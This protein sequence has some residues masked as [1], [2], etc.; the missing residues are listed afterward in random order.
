MKVVMLSAL[1]FSSSVGAQVSE[2]P[3]F[4]PA[5]DT[6]LADVPLHHQG[7]GMVARQRLRGAGLTIGE[8]NG[9]GDLQGLRKDAGDGYEVDFGMPAAGMKWLV[10]F[11]G[12]NGSTTWWERLDSREASCK[13]KVVKKN[14]QGMTTATL[15]CE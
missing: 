14:A 10:C 11:Y 6:E 13:L 12:E 15:T 7:K 9:G 1:I 8:F 4:Y 2:C 3:A 5:K